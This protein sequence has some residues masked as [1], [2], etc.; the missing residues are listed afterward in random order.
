MRERK[1]RFKVHDPVWV[2]VSG[3]KL[4]GVVISRRSNQN[5]FDC[6]TYLVEFES[7]EGFKNRMRVRPDVL[8]YRVE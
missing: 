5:G 8:E 4:K 2:N 1:Y 6:S 7:R 3:E